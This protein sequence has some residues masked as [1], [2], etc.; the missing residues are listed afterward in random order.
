MLRRRWA[1]AQAGILR[2]LRASVSLEWAGRTLRAVTSVA[3]ES[4]HRLLSSVVARPTLMCL[5]VS[6]LHISQLAGSLILWTRAW[7]ILPPAVVYGG[8]ITSHSPLSSARRSPTRSSSG[9]ILLSAEDFCSRFL[10]WRGL[11]PG[12]LSRVNSV[13]QSEESKAANPS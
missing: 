10:D 7:T 11:A 9:R 5:A 6:Q 2:R 1:G 8:A 12:E 13:A 3:R 4:H